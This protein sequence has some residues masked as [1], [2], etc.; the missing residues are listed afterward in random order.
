MRGCDA[1]AACGC[2]TDTCVALMLRPVASVLAGAE[3]RPMARQHRCVLWVKMSLD[4]MPRITIVLWCS[5]RGCCGRAARPVPG[6]T[7]SCACY[8]LRCL[9]LRSMRQQET[10]PDGSTAHSAC[11]LPRKTCRKT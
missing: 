5:R 11:L 6:S 2:R 7:A 9:T 4:A 3:V 10:T 8:T 1:T